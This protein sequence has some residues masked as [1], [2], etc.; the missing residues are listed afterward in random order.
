MRVRAANGVARILKAEGV[1]WV[2]TFPV[3]NV[4]NALGE[5]G[6]PLLMMRDERYA[7]AVA[8]AFSRITGGKSIGVC[9]V[10]GALNPAGLQMAYGALAQAYEDSSPL[11]C[12]TDGL[13][14][15]SGNQR[16]YDLTDGF[17]SVTRWIGHID[18]PD[19]VPELLRRAFTYLRTGRSGPVLLTLPRGL[20]EYDEA[21]HPYTTVKGWR[22]AP[23]RA[24]VFSAVEALR[25]AKTPLLYVG[26]GIFYADATE[27]LLQFAELTG[28]PVLTTLQGQSA[29]PQNHPLSVGVRGPLANHYLETADVVF[30]IGT[31]LSKG[32]FRHIVPRPHEK[33]IILCSADAEDINRTYRVDHAL[34][35]DAK[36]TLQALLTEL[37]TS[38]PARTAPAVV[39]EIREGKERLL[40]EYRP[41]MESDEVPINPY[42]VY[43]DLMKVLDRTRSMVTHDSGNTRD[44]LSTIYEALVPR[45]FVGWGNV[46]TLGFGLA[47]AMAAK[48]AYPDRQCVNVTGD[49]GVGYMIGNMEALVRLRVGVTTIHINNGGFAGYGPGFWGGGHDPYTCEVSDHTKADW[50]KAVRALGYYAEDVQHPDDIIPALGRALDENAHDRPAYLEILCKPFPVFG[51]WIT[52]GSGGH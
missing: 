8:D 34:I 2:A 27:E 16:R 50:S 35:G 19:R 41:F 24:D 49:A 43:G 7:V 25:G 14:P 45:G 1:P 36:L 37:G 18:Q 22:W 30:A 52:A 20:G 48:L 13:P 26:S 39:Q 4:N 11:L 17:R 12:I 44:Q 32:G 23:D 5:E 6:V 10:M 15:G 51:A 3:C 47:V 38:G 29:F 28:M 42:R 9:T 31:S 40:A 46:T 33:T 21:E